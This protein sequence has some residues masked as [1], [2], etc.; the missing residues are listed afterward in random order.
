MVE[1]FFTTKG[2]EKGTGLGLSQVYGFAYR[3]GGTMQIHSEVGSGT[4]ITIYLPRSHAADRR[5][6][7]RRRRD[8]PRRG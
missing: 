3:S 8:L 2:P 1:P 4:T 7:A 5:G 6:I